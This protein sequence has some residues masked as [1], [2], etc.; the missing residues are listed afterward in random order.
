MKSFILFTYFEHLLS[1]I[2]LNAHL[3]LTLDFSGIDG[4]D[5]LPIESKKM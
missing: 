5:L 1:I 3:S 2:S 4:Y